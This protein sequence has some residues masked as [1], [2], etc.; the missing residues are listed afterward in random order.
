MA[1]QPHL[2]PAS[3]DHKGDKKAEL[4]REFDAGARPGVV[5]ARRV[6]CDR[7]YTYEVYDEW[8]KAGGSAR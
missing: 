6:Q 2:E 5:I 8:L 4:L 3:S 7:A 1:T